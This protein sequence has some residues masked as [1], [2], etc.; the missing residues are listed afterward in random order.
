MLLFVSASS[1]PWV[2]TEEGD[3]QEDKPCEEAGEKHE[4]QLDTAG[5]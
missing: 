4:A 2:L 3:E 1:V 5:L